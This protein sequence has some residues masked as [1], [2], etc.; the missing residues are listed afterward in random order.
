MKISMSSR[1]DLEQIFTTGAKP[2]VMGIVNLDPKSFYS[3]S[4]AHSEK[5]AL[6]MV[7][8][9]IKEGMDIL[10]LGAFSS[11]PGAKIPPE[12]VEYQL[13]M[14]ILKKIRATFPDLSISIDTMRASVAQSSLDLGADIIND[15]SG[16]SYDCN[17][18]VLMAKKQAIYIAMH[19]K[20]IPENMQHKD[21]TT[22]INVVD[23][24]LTYFQQKIATFKTMGLHKLIIDPGF[25]FSKKPA[26]NYMLLRNISIF[27]LLGK[28]ILVGVSRKSMIWKLNNSSAQDALVGSIVAG[29]YAL[30]NSCNILRVHD[31]K[32]TNQMLN[33][34]YS[35]QDPS[36]LI[37]HQL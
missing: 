32:E 24:V 30:L 19:M 20:G 25:G 3:E 34:F 7:E 9:K 15:I 13:I 1:N 2:L 5:L 6:N 37:K 36:S 12:D 22:Y 17:L 23:E 8:S 14:P 29:F 31:V 21:N 11:R 28:P 18:P 10:D 26:D 35:I 4:I 33:V 16:G 27:N